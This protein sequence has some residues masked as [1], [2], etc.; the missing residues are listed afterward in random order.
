MEVG[1]HLSRHC[2]GP[3]GESARH[4]SMPAL[5]SICTLCT[6]AAAG[7]G[8]MRPSPCPCVVSGRRSA[9]LS[10]E[11]R[12]PNSKG[13]ELVK[14]RDL[15]PATLS[16]PPSLSLLRCIGLLLASY[17]PTTH[18]ATQRPRAH[19]CGRR[20]RRCSGWT[21]VRGQKGTG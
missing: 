1:A 7:G 20:G 9:S 6:A 11:R 5:C 8:C 13:N 10:L 17:E 21:D 2:T 3:S 12:R 15:W 14:H 16:L 19:P 18:T 4:P